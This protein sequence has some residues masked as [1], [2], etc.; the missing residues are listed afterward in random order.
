MF[1]SF[2]PRMCGQSK[3]SG[4]R[5]CPEGSRCFGGVCVWTRFLPM[6]RKYVGALQGQVQSGIPVVDRHTEEEPG[7]EEVEIRPQMNNW[8]AWSDC[9]TS[10]GNGT[11]S[12]MRRCIDVAAVDVEEKFLESVAGEQ[13][14]FVYGVNP[15]DVE[16]QACDD[17]PPCGKL[18]LAD[19]DDSP[20]VGIPSNEDVDQ[21]DGYKSLE[22]I[23]RPI[24]IARHVSS[25]FNCL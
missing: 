7:G 16:E 11:R 4:I 22:G 1:Y 13:P 6:W 14:S 9:S 10:C 20:D 19:A 24:E 15:C 12:R 2:V 25:S 5:R 23:T 8:S 18:D 21:S 17:N 3:D